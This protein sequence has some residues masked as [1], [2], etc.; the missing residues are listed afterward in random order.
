MASDDQ[1]VHLM[2]MTTKFP[3]H[4][5][6]ENHKHP[7]GFQFSVLSAFPVRS[8]GRIHLISTKY[9]L[10]V[11]RCCVCVWDDTF[12][13][14]SHTWGRW[15]HVFPI[16][17]IL[18]LWQICLAFTIKIYNFSFCCSTLACGT[19]TSIYWD[20][21]IPLISHLNSMFKS[22]HYFLS[23]QFRST[24]LIFISFSQCLC[25]MFKAG[26]DILWDVVSLIQHTLF[27][28]PSPSL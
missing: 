1:R 11:W 17:W 2:R 16:V 18:P 4:L 20:N 7:P 10:L 13:R 28:F 6:L 24:S 22:W 5:C 23:V 25:V 8:Y 9:R 12:R 14:S 19:S 15:K 26:I 27:L 3:K 21:T